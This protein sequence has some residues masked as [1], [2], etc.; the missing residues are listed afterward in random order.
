MTRLA[1]RPPDLLRFGR[2]PRYL[3]A[4][5]V[6]LMI[7]MALYLALL[8]AAIA[9][10]PAAVVAYGAGVGAHWLLS[11]RAVFTGR[12][13]A[14]GRARHRQKILFV[15]SAIAGMAV[16]ALVVALGGHLGVDPRLAKLAA[17]GVSFVVTWWLRAVLVFA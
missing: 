12:V 17:V 2:L 3:V 13:A 15:G 6:A 11:S 7:D 4:S 16:T 9:A 10:T 8:H 14:R 1:A 5:V